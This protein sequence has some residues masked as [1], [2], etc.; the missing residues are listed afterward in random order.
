MRGGLRRNRSFEPRM[1]LIDTDGGFRNRRPET[2][3]RNVECLIL[4]DPRSQVAG[5]GNEEAP[6]FN[7]GA[8]SGAWTRFLASREKSESE[9]PRKHAR[10]FTIAVRISRITG[11]G[12]NLGD[13]RAVRNSKSEY[14]NPKQIQMS[15]ASSA[16]ALAAA[17]WKKMIETKLSRLSCFELPPRTFGR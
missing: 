2:G 10:F 9:N 6:G 11:R 4:V 7:S 8:P 15:E 12:K 14:R 16:K 17:E 5:V 13:R 3:D 1:T